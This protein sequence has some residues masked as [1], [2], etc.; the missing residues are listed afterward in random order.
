MI[1]GLKA[2]RAGRFR[3]PG[4]SSQVAL[5]G[6]GVPRRPGATLGPLPLA[7]PQDVLRVNGCEEAR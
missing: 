4:I 3:H 1:D 6:Q 7:T 5:D 2:R